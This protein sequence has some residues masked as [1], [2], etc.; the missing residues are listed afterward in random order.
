MACSNLACFWPDQWPSLTPT[1]T[2]GMHDHGSPGRTARRILAADSGKGACVDGGERRRKE[3]LG[4]PHNPPLR[5]AS[6]LHHSRRRR[7]RHAQPFVA[8]KTGRWVPVCV[9]SRHDV[10]SW[11]MWPDVL[12]AGRNAPVRSSVGILILWLGL[13]CSSM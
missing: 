8:P 3:H 13:G 2:C 5:A 12:I 1:L 11:A 9:T 6:R 7:H 10:T 4:L